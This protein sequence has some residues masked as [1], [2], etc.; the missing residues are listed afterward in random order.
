MVE[1]LCHVTLDLSSKLMLKS[2][3]IYL[4]K[5]WTNLPILKDHLFIFLNFVHKLNSVIVNLTNKTYYCLL[6]LV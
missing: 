6:F 5:E 4:P 3:L 2:V 1:T